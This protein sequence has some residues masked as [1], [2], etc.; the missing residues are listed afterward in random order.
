MLSASFQMS[1]SLIMR[2]TLSVMELI[3]RG[4]L[5]VVGPIKKFFPFYR[6]IALAT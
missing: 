2:G 3:M 1:S 6:P 5:G 4:S